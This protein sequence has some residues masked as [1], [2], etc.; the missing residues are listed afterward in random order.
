M[1]TARK[2]LAM[3]VFDRLGLTSRNRRLAIYWLSLWDGDRMPVRAQFQPAA[4]RALL[5]SIGIF[6]VNP[7]IGTHCRLAGTGLTRAIGRDLTGLSW[8]DYTPPDERKLRLDRNSAIATGSVGIG[9]RYTH[10]S[11]GELERVVELQLPFADM[12]EDGTRQILFHLDWRDPRL[13]DSPTPAP[14]GPCIAEQFL[15]VPLN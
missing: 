15:A 5:P 2:D 12:A 6:A 3:Q 10:D 7:G 8:K 9:V 13:S 4:V 14:E 1:H 11:R